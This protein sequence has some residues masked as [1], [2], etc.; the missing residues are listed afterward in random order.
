MSTETPSMVY[1]HP[2]DDSDYWTSCNTDPAQAVLEYM[3][4]RVDAG[5][6]DDGCGP[7]LLVIPEYA[8]SS[9]RLT[10]EEFAD[11]HIVHGR[12]EVSV[13]E[14]LADFLTEHTVPD[15]HDPIP[16]NPPGGDEVVPHGV[17]VLRVRAA[18]RAV[19]EPAYRA[20]NGEW[21]PGPR[22]A[23]TLEERKEI[24]AAVTEELRQ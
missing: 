15:S 6:W 5:D 8:V 4:A 24:L 9:R 17:S 16:L 20:G 22:H 2:D 7:S 3:L 1:H 11:R 21:V 23:L 14:M 13:G 10:W 19:L 18:I 12:L